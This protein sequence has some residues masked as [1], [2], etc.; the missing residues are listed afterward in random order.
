MEC[1]HWAT[2]FPVP[3]EVTEQAHSGLTASSML[4]GLHDVHSRDLA[5][6][7]LDC[8]VYASPREYRLSEAVHSRPI[9]PHL[10]FDLC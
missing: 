7:S 8:C 9:Q 10:P 2:V 1:M 6:K 3:V 4:L 5:L